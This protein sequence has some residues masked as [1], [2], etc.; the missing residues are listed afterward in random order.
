MTD[1]FY[2]NGQIRMPVDGV[3]FADPPEMKAKSL[4]LT[5]F[6][7][8]T[9]GRELDLNVDAVPVKISGVEGSISLNIDTVD[10]AGVGQ[11]ADAPWD[12][13]GTSASAVAVQKFAAQLLNAIRTLLQGYLK[14][15]TG[16]GFAASGKAPV[17]GNFT[18][19]GSGDPFT[20]LAG[21]GFNVIIGT[22]GVALGGTVIQIERALDGVNFSPLTFSDGTVINYA[23]GVNIVRGEDQTGV[24]YRLRCT[25]YGGT[26]V[27]WRISQ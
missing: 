7:S 4:P 24:P 10:L 18:G 8:R 12:G 17:S 2:L 27:G 20:P 5:G 25:A 11:P 19:A 9:L 3:P 1:L 26:A 23:T 21:R 15:S 13:A 6:Y 14:V 22:P 16:D